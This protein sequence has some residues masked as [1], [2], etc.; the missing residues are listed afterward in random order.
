MKLWHQKSLWKSRTTLKILQT[1][2]ISTVTL[3]N[4]QCSKKKIF[5]WD[6]CAFLYKYIS[7]WFACIFQCAKNCD[8]R[9]HSF[10]VIFPSFFK[11][12]YF[13]FIPKRAPVKTSSKVYICNIISYLR[14]FLFSHSVHFLTGRWIYKLGIY[15]LS[16]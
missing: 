9:C 15:A 6:Q 2:E 5:Q 13:S 16:L 1:K 10:I 7:V 4:F 3:K 8:F 11:M 12:D 14:P